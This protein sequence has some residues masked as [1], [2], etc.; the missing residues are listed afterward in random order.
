MAVQ[1][2]IG[3]FSDIVSNSQMF[4]QSHNIASQPIIPAS[5]SSMDRTPFIVAKAGIGDTYGANDVMHWNSHKW[6]DMNRVV[7]Q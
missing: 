2:Q 4:A 7:G 5:I 6:G 1:T 3:F